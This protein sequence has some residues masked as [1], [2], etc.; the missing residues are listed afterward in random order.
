MFDDFAAYFYENIVASYVAYRDVR[1]NETH[2]RSQDTRAALVAATALYHLREHIPTTKQKTRKEIASECPDYDVLGD[3][4]NAA[5]HRELDRGAPKLRSAE[6]IY[7]L[8]VITQYEDS[9]GTYSD[10]QKVVM[11]K[12]LDGTEKDILE[13]LTNVMNYWGNEFVR[14]GFSE[15]YKPFDIPPGP[16][17]VYVS[18]DAARGLGTEIIRGVRFKQTIKLQKFNS[19]TGKLGPFDL[20]GYRPRYRIYK[21][22]YVVDIYLSHPTTGKKYLFELK[23][24]EDQSLEWHSLK[25]DGAREEFAARLAQERQEE[26]LDL[27][28][29]K[30]ADDSGEM[31]S[32]KHAAGT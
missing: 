19:A 16:G 10:A 1:E 29:A 15:S 12:L 13:C 21:P 4:V 27:L 9:E 22:S 18:R 11:V 2:G 30:I 24:D 6:D 5:K 31:P 7:E 26:I 25:T 17:E 8:T 3:V 20:T 32:A 14:L 23:L 28:A